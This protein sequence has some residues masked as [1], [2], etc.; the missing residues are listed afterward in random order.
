MRIPSGSQSGWGRQAKSAKSGE[1]QQGV[2]PSRP[3]DREHGGMGLQALFVAL[4]ET[5]FVL[6]LDNFEFPTLPSPGQKAE[7]GIGYHTMSVF[8]NGMY[9]TEL[10]VTR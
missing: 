6:A 10:G 4:T 3:L 8:K 5:G 2:T 7:K 9:V 1:G